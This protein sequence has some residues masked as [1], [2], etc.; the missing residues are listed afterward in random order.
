MPGYITES[1]VP[2][3]VTLPSRTKPLAVTWRPC[4]ISSQTM[5][6]G[7]SRSVECACITSPNGL[8]SRSMM[9]R[10]KR[11]KRV[12]RWSSANES[13]RRARTENAAFTGFT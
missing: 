12:W 13:T 11:P 3:M 1:T 2:S 5:L 10:S 9:A 4:A 6:K 8:T 7:S